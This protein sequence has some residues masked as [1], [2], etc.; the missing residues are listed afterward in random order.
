VVQPDGTVFIADGAP[1]IESRERF[2][3]TEQLEPGGHFRPGPTLE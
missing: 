3:D 1:E 2:T